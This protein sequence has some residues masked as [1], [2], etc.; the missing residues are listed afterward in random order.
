MRSEEKRGSSSI[1]FKER[2]AVFRSVVVG[3][4]MEI[5]GVGK[6]VWVVVGTVSGAPLTT[7]SVVPFVRGVVV[8]IV[9]FEEDV[10]GLVR[11]PMMG[12]MKSRF[13]G[14]EFRALVAETTPTKR[15]LLTRGLEG[16][17]RV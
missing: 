2:E 11:W 14:A 13:W 7:G 17:W 10:R 6:T 12:E 5:E 16:R 3:E 8:A 9:V 1:G 4:S 15:L